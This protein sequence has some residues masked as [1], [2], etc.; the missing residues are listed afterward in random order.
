[1]FDAPIKEHISKCLHRKFCKHK[2]MNNFKKNNPTEGW[3]ED[4]KYDFCKIENK[5]LKSL[6]TGK[7]KR[8][9]GL[10][11]TSNDAI[12]SSV[13]EINAAFQ[14]DILR[15]KEIWKHLCHICDYATNT[16]YHLT[17]HIAVHGIIQFVERFKCD[18]CDKDFAQKSNMRTVL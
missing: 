18:K 9:S 13:E 16:K 5:W 2:I 14:Y 11:S 4:E 8:N 15:R 1:M 17:R 7:C 3:T 6:P 10:A 12:F